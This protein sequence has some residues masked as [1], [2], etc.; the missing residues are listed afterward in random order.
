MA[1]R[2]TK[3]E[4]FQKEEFDTFFREEMKKAP[5]VFKTHAFEATYIFD[6]A[7]AF[8]KYMQTKIADKGWTTMA[9]PQI[10][11]GNNAPIID[12]FLF[13]ASQ[14]YHISP[15]VDEFGVSLFAPTLMLFANE[16]QK[17]RL[18]KPIAKGEVNYCQGWSE[19][20]AGSDLASLQTYARKDGDFYVVNGQKIWTTGGHR[21]DHMF[22]LARTDNTE[23]RSKGLSVFHLNMNTPG[24]EVKP[25]LYLNRHR[26]YNEIFFSDVK[27]HRRDLIGPEN[28]GWK[29][30][31]ETMNFERSGIGVFSWLQRM[32]EELIALVQTTQKDGKHL[33]Q[34]EWV[35]K[36]LSRL[37]IDI[38]RGK[39]LTYDIAQEQQRKGLAMSPALA[40]IAKVFGSELRQRF[41]QTASGI[42]GQWAQL[43]DSEWAPLQGAIPDI[44][45]FSLGHNLAAGSSEIQRNIIAWT[46]A[47][48]PR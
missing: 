36:E 43:Y 37:Y 32:M 22:L 3:Q 26:V 29:L 13:K 33:W 41:A 10:Y 1:F 44:Y 7:W 5:A 14:A 28:Q 18:L 30:T 11:G 31:R 27:I 38:E 15:G 25:I 19:P 39:A 20:N 12:Q 17:K 47:G 2:L 16:E 8:H 21:A 35:Q 24:I 48:L 42:L 6:E 4:Q 34:K 9:W 23:K 46:K 40:S 45:E